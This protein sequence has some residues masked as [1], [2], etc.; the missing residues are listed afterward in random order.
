MASGVP[1]CEMKGYERY[2][3]SGFS[4]FSHI[5]RKETWRKKVVKHNYVRFVVLTLVVRH[6]HQPKCPRK[7][8]RGII[9]K[10]YKYVEW[11]SFD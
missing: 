9:A 1:A 3:S 6:T 10:K 2:T 4:S 7:H 5:A 8:L 11:P